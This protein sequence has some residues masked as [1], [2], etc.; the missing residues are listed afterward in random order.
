MVYVRT[1][2]YCGL[3]FEAARSNARYCGGA[4]RNQASRDRARARQQEAQDQARE[5]FVA[6]ATRRELAEHDRQDTAAGL[7]AL[8][9]A[10]RIDHAERETGSSFAAVVREH[11][12]TLADALKGTVPQGDVVDEVR[13]KRE[14]HRAARSR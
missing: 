11:R 12:R 7:A 9:L 2:D 8:A 1:C 5:G 4:H 14:Q 13:A 10:G 3:E 6:S